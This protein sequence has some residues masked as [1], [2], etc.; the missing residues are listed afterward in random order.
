MQ[1]LFLDWQ[2][3]NEKLR[4][5]FEKLKVTS[6]QI[7]EIL[8]LNSNY[9]QN[10]LNFVEKLEIQIRKVKNFLKKGISIYHICFEVNNLEKYIENLTNNGCI[11]ISSLTPA[12][13]FKGR[14]VVFLVTS[15]GFL[16]ELLEAE[17]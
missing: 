4:N 10:L 12:I 5:N 17:T 3:K 13:L 8:S 14:K 9:Q 7:K 6:K 16:I 2:R 15:M 1:K 11:L